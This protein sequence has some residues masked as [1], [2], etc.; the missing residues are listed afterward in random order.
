M[1]NLTNDIWVAGIG[2]ELNDGY[3]CGWYLFEAFSLL[4]F[5][6]TVD[7]SVVTR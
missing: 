7:L 5:V 2:Y 6:Q 3:L 1:D 4:L